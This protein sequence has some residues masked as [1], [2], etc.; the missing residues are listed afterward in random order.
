[1]PKFALADPYLPATLPPVALK[2]DASSLPVR[3]IT[4]QGRSQERNQGAHVQGA[5]VPQPFGRTYR[6]MRDRGGVVT[7][8]APATTADRTAYRFCSGMNIPPK[9]MA[10]GEHES[11]GGY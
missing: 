6:L 1:M 10:L 2:F 5:S 11:A 8:L 4:L 7:H 9:D 3:W